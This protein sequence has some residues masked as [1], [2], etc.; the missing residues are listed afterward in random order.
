MI[1]DL[2]ELTEL[3]RAAL[4]AAYEC[5][6]ITNRGYFRTQT[7]NWLR[8]KDLLEPFNIEEDLIGD[9]WTTVTWYALTPY[10]QFLVEK[11]TAKS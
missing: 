10:G 1:K 3:R 6:S 5:D 4:V 7:L 8:D 2:S 11:S 9:K